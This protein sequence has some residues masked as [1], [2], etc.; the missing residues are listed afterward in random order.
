[1][2]LVREVKT[3]VYFRDEVRHT[4]NSDLRV[5]QMLAFGRLIIPERG[6]ARVT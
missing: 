6:V 3:E 5:C 4:E 2:K 1:V